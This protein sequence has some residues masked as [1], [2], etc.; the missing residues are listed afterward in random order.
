M[1][2]VDLKCECGLEGRVWIGKASVDFTRWLKED[3]P[4]KISN[5]EKNYPNT[6]V[7]F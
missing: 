2:S 7:H 5:L 6:Y 4:I 3:V 1:A